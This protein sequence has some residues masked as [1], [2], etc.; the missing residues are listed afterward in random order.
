MDL[1][2]LQVRHCGI[3]TPVD[4]PVERFDLHKMILKNGPKNEPKKSCYLFKQA[5]LLKAEMVGDQAKIDEYTKQ[6]E[7][8]KKNNPNAPQPWQTRAREERPYREERL[9]REERPYRDDGSN[10]DDRPY[11]EE[12]PPF[13]GDPLLPED[14][15]ALNQLKDELNL[16]SSK[17]LKAEML[18]KTDLCA[19]YQA[20]IE[21][22]Q[23]KLEDFKSKLR[24]V[25]RPPPPPPVK[26]PEPVKI[27]KPV[28][29]VKQPERPN[30][31]KPRKMDDDYASNLLEQCKKE[32]EELHS[33]QQ[34][35]PRKITLDPNKVEEMNTLNVL[36]VSA[37]GF[38][39][40]LV[41]YR[42]TI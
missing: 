23:R 19:E 28:K 21:E 4:Q 11:R 14:R 37:F 10:R 18:G 8:F 1:N 25:E 3:T 6:I 40:V 15:K 5:R 29:P 32:I 12:R 41:N 34:G 35:N 42:L 36:N 20:K 22:H 39:A 7:E 24:R 13:R 38:L 16:L 17:K 9:Y 30:P 31:E 2:H 26:P 33:R 27:V